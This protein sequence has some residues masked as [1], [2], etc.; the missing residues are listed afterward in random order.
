MYNEIVNELKNMSANLAKLADSILEK[1]DKRGNLVDQYTN[2]LI[3]NKLEIT[4][5]V[6]GIQKY[7]YQFFLKEENGKKIIDFV[8][9]DASDYSQILDIIIHKLKSD[10]INIIEL[11][12]TKNI[13][14]DDS[15]FGVYEDLTSFDY[16]NTLNKIYKVVFHHFELDEEY[17]KSIWDT[18]ISYCTFDELAS[19]ITPDQLVWCNKLNPELRKELH[20]NN[21]ITEWY[22]FTE[23][24][25]DYKP[26]QNDQ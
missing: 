1:L 18:S 22:D 13:I 20:I 15:L 3:D 7:Y 23:L 16:T 11:L 9:T 8:F 25:K 10:G 26:K 12:D 21:K 17:R 14:V 19:K 24:M 2:Y 4:P 5:L 6:K